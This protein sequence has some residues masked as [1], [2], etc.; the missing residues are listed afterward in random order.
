MT[1]NDVIYGDSKFNSAS[2]YKFVELLFSSSSYL[3]V[4]N[5]MIMSYLED[6]ILIVGQNNEI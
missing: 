1:K 4:H 5:E 2:W 6:R 3:K